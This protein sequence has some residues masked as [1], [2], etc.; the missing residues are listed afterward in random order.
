MTDTSLLESVAPDQHGPGTSASAAPLVA[1][2]RLLGKEPDPGV[3][4]RQI[5]SATRFSN[6]TAACSRRRSAG[7]NE[8]ANASAT[9]ATPAWP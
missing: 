5:R 7:V 1:A 3:D 6:G 2:G 9:T 8:V 4:R